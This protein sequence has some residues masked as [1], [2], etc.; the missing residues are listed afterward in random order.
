M[1]ECPLEYRSESLINLRDFYSITGYTAIVNAETITEYI[2]ARKLGTVFTLSENLEEA[3]GI[4]RG[5]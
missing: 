4:L 5:K 1:I 2:T 3:N